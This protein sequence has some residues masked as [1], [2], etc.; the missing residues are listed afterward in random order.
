M[1]DPR[2]T[3]RLG[4]LFDVSTS[5]PTAN[6][7]LVW[8]AALGK[9]TNSAL[10]GQTTASISWQVGQNPGNTTFFT[11]PAACRVTSIVGFLGAA[12]TLASTASVY[13][14]LSGTALSGGIVLH[15]GSFNAQ[16]T[17]NTNQTL[18]VTAIAGLAY[19]NTNNAYQGTGEG[20]YQYSEPDS[21]LSAGDSIGLVTTGTWALSTGSITVTLVY[22]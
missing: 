2:W 19:Q 10:G 5:G 22:Q 21:Y 20:A 1:T 11:A 12:N 8:N 6:Q 13:R 14:T 16:G 3:V 17:A 9:W 18:I 4:D 7:G 15:S